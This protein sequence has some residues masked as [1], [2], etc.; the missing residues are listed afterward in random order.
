VWGFFVF[1]FVAVCLGVFVLFWHTGVQ[2][3]SL[4]PARQVL[5][6]LGHIQALLLRLFAIYQL[7]SPYCSFESDDISQKGP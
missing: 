4:M 2:T 7:I 5:Y 6:H 3:H 1:V